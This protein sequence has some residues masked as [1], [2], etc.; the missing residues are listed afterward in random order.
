M[1]VPLH[2]VSTATSYANYSIFS[3]ETHKKQNVS[4]NGEGFREGLFLQTGIKGKHSI[5]KLCSQ[6]PMTQ[7]SE[8]GTQHFLFLLRYCVYAQENARFSHY[9]AVTS[10]YYYDA[11]QHPHSYTRVSH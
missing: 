5:L 4:V 7:H 11:R 1:K 3:C 8:P 6:K 9:P 10:P 2:S